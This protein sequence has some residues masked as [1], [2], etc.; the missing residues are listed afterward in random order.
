MAHAYTPGLMVK[1]QITVRKER[2]LPLLGEVLVKKGDSVT[3]ETIVARTEL[4]GPVKAINVANILKIPPQDV[5]GA[6]LVQNGDPVLEKQTI[7]EIKGLFG[8]FTTKCSAPTTGKIENISQ[9]TGQILLREPPQPVEINAYINGKIIEILPKEGVVIET[10]G[11]FIQGIFGVGG[12]THGAIVIAVQSPDEEL[13]A[14]HFKP[15]HKGKIVVGGSFVTY[16]SLQ[17]AIKTGAAG[18]VVGGFDDADLKKLL[19]KDLGVA[20]TGKENLGITL[21]LTEGFGRIPM[22][23]STFKLLKACQG[24]T[25]SMNGATQI[26][27]GVIRPEIIVP[28]GIKA[29]ETVGKKEEI[30]IDRKSTRLNS[31][32]TDISRMPSSA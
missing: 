1:H 14:Q 28:G 11:S 3:N 4:P 16:E 2:K 22:A 21:L 5:P 27:A 31:S 9:V 18:I 24:M 6:M 12:E 7:A 20:I 29:S 13:T 10:T 32:H 17:A 23:A 25:A 8:L 15:E 26:R 19:G 30:G